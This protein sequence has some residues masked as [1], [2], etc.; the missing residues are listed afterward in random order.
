M[1]SIST[2]TSVNAPSLSGKLQTVASWIKVALAAQNSRTALGKLDAAALADIGLSQAQACEEANR[3][4]WDVPAN[5][6]R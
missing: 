4:I 3:P 6:T 1:T 2:N 5:W